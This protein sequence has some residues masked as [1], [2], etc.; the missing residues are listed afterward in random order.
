MIQNVFGYLSSFLLSDRRL[1]RRSQEMIKIQ[2]VE[3]SFGLRVLTRTCGHYKAKLNLKIAGEILSV[4]RVL[5]GIIV[6]DDDGAKTWHWRQVRACHTDF[7]C[8]SCVF[9]NALH[10]GR[11]HA[12]SHASPL[13]RKWRNKIESFTS[14]PTEKKEGKKSSCSRQRLGLPLLNATLLLMLSI[15]FETVKLRSPLCRVVNV[16][17]DIEVLSWNAPPL[18]S[19]FYRFNRVPARF[20]RSS[21]SFFIIAGWVTRPGNSSPGGLEGVVGCRV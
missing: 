14:L 19:A 20:I 10:R 8:V 9:S 13:W 7:I 3:F 12:D 6:V 17:N 5:T 18:I 21:W 11:Y 16:R 1:S 15:K 4:S 2:R